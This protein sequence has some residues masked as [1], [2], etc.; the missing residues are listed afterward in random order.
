MGILTRVAKVT[1]ALLTS[2][3]V[4][5][6]T[7]LLLPP[8]FL[9]KYGTT[10]YGEWIVL[11]GAVAY[12]STLN[13]GIQTYVTQDLTI[14]YH[15]GDM[16]RYHLQQSTALRI[17]LAILGSAALAALVIFALPVHHLLRLT[18]SQSMASLALYLLALQ[19]LCGVLF[20]YFTGMYTV[21]SRAHT[22]VFWANGL[23]LTMVLATSTGAWMRLSFSMLAG[24]QLGTYLIGTLLILLHV[25]RIAPEIFPQMQHWDRSAVRGILRPSGYFGLISMSTFLSYE[26]PIL[27]L[28]RE[29]GPFVVVAFTVMRTIFSMCRQILNAPTQAMAP[30]ITRLFG[31][32]EWA[33]LSQLYRYSERL[34]FAIL[35]VANLGMLLLSPV[36]LGL[37]LHKPQLFS[38]VPYVWMAAISITLSAKEHKFQFQY[39][40]NTH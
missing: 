15:Q 31:R 8:I 37:W 28:Q 26:V 20:G 4:N 35:P 5:L 23:R 13:F 11:S 27:I 19:V 24:L 38:V 40:T 3:V 17:L 22:G 39:A 9:Y 6:T 33:P 21:L 30:E 1:G 34:L 18:I 12:L 10:L 25:R 2:N 14:R 7:K 29:V 32:E 16:Q 36:L